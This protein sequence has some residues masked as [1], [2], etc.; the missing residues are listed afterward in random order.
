MV[1]VSFSQPITFKADEQISQK[2]KARVDIPS[3]SLEADTFEP[4]KQGKTSHQKIANF[5]KFL[6]VTKTMTG[7]AVKGAVY[8]A[9]AYFGVVAAFWPFKALPKAFV[10]ENSVTIGKLI[11]H[12]FKHIGKAGKILSVAAGLTTLGYQ[13]IKGRLDANENTAIIDHK[14]KVGHRDV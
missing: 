5:W 13:L 12:P 3:S 6:S 11:S 10:K 9:L 1:K 2:P 8:G 4:A 7:A 14:L